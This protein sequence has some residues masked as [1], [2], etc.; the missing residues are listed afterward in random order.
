MNLVSKRE[1]YNK[2][3]FVIGETIYFKNE[4]NLVEIKNYR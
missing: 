2:K 1:T 3:F 4:E